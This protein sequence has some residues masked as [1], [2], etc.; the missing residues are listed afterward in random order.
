MNAH[1][2][3]GLRQ[4]VGLST[5]DYDRIYKSWKRMLNRCY[6][7]NNASY[8]HYRSR[9][10]EVCVEWRYSFENFLRWAIS[11]GWKPQLTLDRVDNEGDY[12]PLNCRWATSKTQ[13]RN[14]ST[15]VYLTHNGET[16]TLIEWCEIFG[17]P[18][19]LPSNRIRRG[20]TN[21]DEIFSKVNRVTGGDLHY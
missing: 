21:F 11:N 20:C 17:V 14:R 9:G 2:Y 6:D 18:H 12:E 16:K 10:I 8:C 7:S 4:E 3:P 13:A 15:C 5:K 1:Y 19:Y